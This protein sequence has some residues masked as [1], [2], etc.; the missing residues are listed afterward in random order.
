M[1]KIIPFDSFEKTGNTDIW[2]YLSRPELLPGEKISNILN[3]NLNPLNV[4]SL[5]STWLSTTERYCFQNIEV[6]SRFFAA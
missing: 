6:L 3:W 2:L 1:L 4:R 5:P